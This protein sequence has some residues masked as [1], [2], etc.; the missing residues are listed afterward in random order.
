MFCSSHPLQEESALAES[1]GVPEARIP[2]IV[3]GVCYLFE[4][5]GYHNLKVRLGFGFGWDDFFLEEDREG[6]QS[7]IVYS[8]FLFHLYS[9]S[10]P[11][12]PS[13]KRWASPPTSWYGG[14]FLFLSFFFFLFLLFF[15]LLRV[16]VHRLSRRRLLRCGRTR[17]PRTCRA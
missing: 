12:R 13:W 5:A 9:R 17:A 10:R 8:F 1:L 3:D 2:T 6:M 16:N 7:E 14:R 11:L 15:F 4:T